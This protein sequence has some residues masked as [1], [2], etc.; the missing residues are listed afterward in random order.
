MQDNNITTLVKGMIIGATM[1]IPGVSGGTMAI[2]LGIYDQ[3]IRAVSSFKKEAKKNAFFLLVFTIGAG[4]GAMLFAS[5]LL[6]ILEI[7]PMPTLYFFLGAVFGGIPLIERKAGLQKFSGDVLFCL[8]LGVGS[9]LVF[10]GIPVGQAAG[11]DSVLVFTIMGVV[12]SI[13]LI[14]P[15]ISLSHFFLMMGMYDDLIKGIK[16]MDLHFLV[17]VGVGGILGIVLFTKILEWVLTKYPKQTYMVIL[18]FILA[19]IAQVFPGIPKK[20]ELAWCIGTGIA[21]FYLVHKIG[22]E[23]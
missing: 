1:I 10:S 18:G 13:A 9:V 12:S 6:W 7:F 5:R 20:E 22:R 3:L 11:H 15:G 8:L 14:L 23:R 2:I 17:P 19:S 21:G 16:E 4:G